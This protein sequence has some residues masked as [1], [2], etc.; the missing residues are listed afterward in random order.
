M[1][2]FKNLVVLISYTVF[3]LYIFIISIKSTVFNHYFNPYLVVFSKT[4][5]QESFGFFTKDP[6]DKQL[7]LFKLEYGQIINKINLKTISKENLFGLSRKSRRKLFELGNVVKD[8]PDSLWISIDENSLLK[9]SFDNE[10]PYEINQDVE[11]LLL[12][13]SKYII[14]HFTPIEWEWH[15]LKHAT[16][17]EYAFIEIK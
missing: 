9:K 5:F 4:V 15:D 14:Y 7:K 12:E 17:G 11:V 3:V 13:S 8:I 16:E 1:R 10:I 2:M 6:K